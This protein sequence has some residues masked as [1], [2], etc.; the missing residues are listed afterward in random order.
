MFVNAKK[1]HEFRWLKNL[2]TNQNGWSCGIRI[3]FVKG[4]RPSACRFESDF[5]QSLASLKVRV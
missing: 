5:K 1:W 3:S 4:N 2:G